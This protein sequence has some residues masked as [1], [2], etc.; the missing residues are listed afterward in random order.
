MCTRN[1]KRETKFHGEVLINHLNTYGA[2]PIHLHNIAI[3]DMN[4][5]Q[6]YEK[7]LRFKGA[8][9]GNII[10]DVVFEFDKPFTL[11]HVHHLKEGALLPEVMCDTEDLKRTY[12]NTYMTPGTTLTFTFPFSISP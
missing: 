6:R 12:G 8:S 1:N 7:P 2:L 5:N 4:T 11:T 3:H 10:Y 9:N